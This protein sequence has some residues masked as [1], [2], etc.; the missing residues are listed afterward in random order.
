MRLSTSLTRTLA[1]TAV[2]M[3]LAACGSGGPKRPTSASDKSAAAPPLSERCADYEARGL[4]PPP[5]CPQAQRRT[6]QRGG[7][8]TLPDLPTDPMGGL[9]TLPQRPVLGR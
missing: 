5:E 9:P 6:Q 8:T 7:V 2:V 4:V 3:G 1:V